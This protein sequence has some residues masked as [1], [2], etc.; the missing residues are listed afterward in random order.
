M[1]KVG[2]SKGHRGGKTL[3]C[4]RESNSYMS[5]ILRCMVFPVSSQA[6]F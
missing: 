1:D 3:L 6:R 2:V 5:A 4:F